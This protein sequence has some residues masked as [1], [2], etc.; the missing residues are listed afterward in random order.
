MFIY[1]YRY[2]YN[3]YISLKI[4]KLFINEEERVEEGGEEWREVERAINDNRSGNPF[5]HRVCL[6][7]YIDRYLKKL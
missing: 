7:I 2:I 3:I 4:I 6:Y 1:I 5:I